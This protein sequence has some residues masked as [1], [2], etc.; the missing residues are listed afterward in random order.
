MAAMCSAWLRARRESM[1]G[2]AAGGERG[3]GR[4]VVG[5]VAIPVGEAGDV[6]GVA[7]QRRRDDRSDPVDLGEGCP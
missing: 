7:D 4:A 1:D 6:T 3:G 2:A 5:G